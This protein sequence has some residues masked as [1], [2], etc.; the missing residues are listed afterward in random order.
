M[1][2]DAV[3]IRGETVQASHR[4]ESG[5]VSCARCGG[6]V[7]NVKPAWNVTVIY[8]TVVPDLPFQPVLHLHYGERVMDIADGLPKF[9]DGPEQIGG[10]GELTEEPAKTGYR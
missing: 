2:S 10:T 4:D 8:A 5:R 1:A 3:E 9:V 6:A 7:A